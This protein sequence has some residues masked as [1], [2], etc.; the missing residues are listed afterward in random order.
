MLCE[1]S[2]VRSLPRPQ[3]GSDW[4]ACPSEFFGSRTALRH[5]STEAVT[6]TQWQVLRRGFST[7]MQ[8]ERKSANTLRLYL[9]AIDELAGWVEANDSPDDLRKLTRTDLALFMAAM[10]SYYRRKGSRRW[11]NGAGRGIEGVAARM[12]DP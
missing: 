8:A 4:Q 5:R 2:Q 7:S 1:R 11:V 9:G 3:P 10:N 12:G 6:T